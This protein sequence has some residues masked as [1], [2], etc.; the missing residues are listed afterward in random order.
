MKKF[1][2]VKKQTKSIGKQYEM[3]IVYTHTQIIQF[4]LKL[5]QHQIQPTTK[6]QIT[7]IAVQYGD[8][9]G[10]KNKI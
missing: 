5:V 2:S 3:H 9:I 1:F 6:P 10:R 4:N 8:N 7:N